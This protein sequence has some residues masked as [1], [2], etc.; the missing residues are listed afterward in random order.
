M[1]EPFR[2][3]LTVLAILLV[4]VLLI[5]AAWMFG[6]T[7]ENPDSPEARRNRRIGWCLWVA[8]TA[9]TAL[10]TAGSME[11][12]DIALALIPALGLIAEQILAHWR[13]RQGIPPRPGERPDTLTP[14]P[15]EPLRVNRLDLPN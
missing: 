7:L 12:I 3:A 4:P 2:L 8:W 1:P 10:R 15:D 6:R 5:M 11:A 14:P 9:L 13:R